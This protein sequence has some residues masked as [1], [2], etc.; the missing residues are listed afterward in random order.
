[1]LARQV[2]L[3]ETRN[4]EWNPTLERV[5]YIKDEWAR[6]ADDGLHRLCQ[7]TRRF[8]TPLATARQDG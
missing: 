6:E 3:W 4:V 1:M 5:W 8:Q 2:V 7:S